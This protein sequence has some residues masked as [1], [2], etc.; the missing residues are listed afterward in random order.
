MHQCVNPHC[1]R[2]MSIRRGSFFH[3]SKFDIHQQMLII[4]CFCEDMKV[5]VCAR[6][7]GISRF[8]ATNYYDNLRGCYQDALA[9]SPIQ[10]RSHGPYEVDEFQIEHVDLGRG[11][12]ST[13]WVQDILERETGRYWA[14]IVPN[15]SEETLVGNI[16][17]MIPTSSL[18]FT[19]DWSAY[20]S[21]KRR[22]YKHYTVTHSKKEYSRQ[23][24]IQQEEVLVGINTLEGLH[25]GIRQRLMNKKRRNSTRMELHLAE[26][27]YRKSG[28]SLFDPFKID[29]M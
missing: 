4:C 6:D 25:H 19:D 10:F 27:I 28:R 29:M 20:A 22:G 21:L 9:I 16:L 2:V 26:F 18:I 13:V 14:S 5:S 8:H 17:D 1:R 23:V 3:H 12:Y 7:L 11:V 15:R 24:L